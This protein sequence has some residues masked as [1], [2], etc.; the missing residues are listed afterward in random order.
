M[1]FYWY[2]GDT[3]IHE[4]GITPEVYIE[5]DEID[6]YMMDLLNLTDF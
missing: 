6:A 1:Y 3:N 4:V 5:N 2:V